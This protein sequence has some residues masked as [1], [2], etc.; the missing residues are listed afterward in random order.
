[1]RLA[2]GILVALSAA[3]VVVGLG[4]SWLSSYAAPADPLPGLIGV[5]VA[6]AC[7]VA[8]AGVWTARLSARVALVLAA[9]APVATAIGSASS[10]DLAVL[11]PVSMLAWLVVLLLLRARRARAW[12]AA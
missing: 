8:A 7:L 1:V 6:T 2:A 5:G 3:G 11:A 10:V 9:G 12:L 4:I